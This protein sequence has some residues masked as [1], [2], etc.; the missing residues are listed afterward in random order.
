MSPTSVPIAGVCDPR[1]APVREA[2]AGNFAQHDEIGAA[3]TLLVGGRKVADLWGGWADRARTRPWTEDTLVNFFSIGKAIAA[4]CVLRLV[5]R[6]QLDLDAPVARG[7]PQFAAAGKGEVTL[8]QLMAHRAG[9]PAIGPPLLPA[10]KMLDW[11]LMVKRLAAQAPWW[12]PNEAHGYHVNTY[13]YLLG[14]PVRRAAGMTIGA[15]LRE[16]IAGPLGA[17]VHFGLPRSE[18]ARV[19]EFCYALPRAPAAGDP[20][21]PPPRPP[22]THDELM[23]A[24][25]YS[26]PPGVSGGVYVNTEAWRL[27]EIPSTNGHGT[28]RGVA[29]VYQGLLEGLIDADLLAEATTEHAAGQDRILERP[30]RFGL[31]YQL[32]QAERPLGPN[33]GAFG[34]FGAGGSLGFCDPEAGVA[35]GYVMNDMGPR[36]QNPRNK[37]LI[38]AVYHCL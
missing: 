26:N 13:G 24:C 20:P 16:D 23:R 12:P 30:S 15:L 28:A 25:A 21:P 5:Q 37:A 6:G 31:G 35:F 18:H 34:H 38:E 8:R 29:Q 27:A 32:T 1:F 33:V 3:V 9:L 17:D 19:A 36:W 10:G 11:D 22:A 4:T 2:F 7:W 14:E